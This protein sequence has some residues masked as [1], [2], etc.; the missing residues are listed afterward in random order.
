[1]SLQKDIPRWNF[2]VWC[3]IYF[4]TRKY[5][6]T[7]NIFVTREVKFF[8]RYAFQTIVIGVSPSSFHKRT[9]L[10]SISS[11]SIW[12]HFLSTV[13]LRQTHCLNTLS[14]IFL[15]SPWLWQLIYSHDDIIFSFPFKAKH[16]LSPGTHP[17]S[18]LR[19]Q[20]IFFL[21]KAF[22]HKYL[23]NYNNYTVV[24]LLYLRT[25]TSTTATLTNL[26]TH[27]FKLTI[28]ISH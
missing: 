23:I 21:D 27:I 1:M 26:P 25:G 24:C 4:Q 13:H 15:G 9:T 10:V 22:K 20:T 5:R 3:Y 12:I 7:I 2:F 28:I 14:I 17:F 11:P 18:V 19:K 16:T 6:S 8:T